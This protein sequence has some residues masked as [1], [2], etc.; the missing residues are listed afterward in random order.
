MRAVRAARARLGRLSGRTRAVGL[1]FATSLAGRG[2][3]VA[4]QLLQVPIAV[5]VLGTEVFGLWMVLVGVSTVITFA[6]FGVGQGAQNRL[7]EA[8][9]GGREAE[10]RE[11]AGSA[12]AFLAAAGALLAGVGLAVAPAVDWSAVFHLTGPRVRTE[13]GTA[14]ATAIALFC[15]NFPLGF[16]QRLAYA[17]QLG[18]R[19]NLAQAAGA[20]GAL[21]GLVLAAERGWSLAGVIA[22]TQGAVLAANAGLLVW[23]LAELG[24]LRPGALRC[25][26]TAMRPLL[27]LGAYFGVQQVL[28]TLMLALPPVMISTRLGAAAV[29]PYNLAQR[30]FN[31]FA[32]VQNAFMLPLWPAYS[33]A[34][35]R[36]DH[37]WIR[38]M[39]GWSLAATL[40]CTIA[41]MTAGALLA[42]PLISR[43]V[44]VPAALPSEPLVWALFLWNAAVFLQ[45][46]FGYL[47]AGLSEVRRLTFYAGVSAVASAGLMALAV[48][49]F[50]ATGAVLG[51]FAGYLP[52]LV[53]GN[54]AEAIRVLRRDRARAAPCAGLA[55]PPAAAEG[56]P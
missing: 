29:T 3:G 24:W 8:F 46:P 40:G 44:H 14:V 27:G 35:A 18:W 32:I 20:V 50:G 55:P 36:G 28:L 33:D 13:A 17:R 41:P 26:W 1:F 19:N 12:L 51:L 31:F 53:A 42:R 2:I 34:H 16:A 47:L 43:W 45:Q 23:Q 5:R 22:A 54:I 38:R 4:C 39:L 11:I 56:S 37:R 49:R 9:A 52:F 15:A 21:G 10:A 25:R 7:A 6:D 30:L 48:R